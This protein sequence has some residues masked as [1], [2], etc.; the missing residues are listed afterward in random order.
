[1]GLDMNLYGRKFFRTEAIK[2]KSLPATSGFFFGQSDGSEDEESIK[3]LEKAI[4]WLE[5]E[6]QGV[7]RSVY[8]EASW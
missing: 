8:Y 5:H 4:A 6:E 1:M 7:Y 3:I 2:A